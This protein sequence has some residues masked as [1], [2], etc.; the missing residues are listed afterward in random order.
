MQIRLRVRE[1]GEERKREGKRAGNEP[2]DR[3][4]ERESFPT[5]CQA[6]CQLGVAK[7]SP[8]RAAAA[9]P[10]LCANPLEVVGVQRQLTPFNITEYSAPAVD[11]ES[12]SGTRV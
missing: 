11:D 7:F 5:S 2:T 8:K 1:G 4:S 9:R 12:P 6:G 3:A 10:K